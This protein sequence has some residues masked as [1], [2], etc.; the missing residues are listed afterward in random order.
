MKSAK[1]KW[2][3]ANSKPKDVNQYYLCWDKV[4]KCQCIRKPNEF[5]NFSKAISYWRRQPP[6]PNVFGLYDH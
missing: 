1:T 6:N 2:R 4:A 3:S 5:G